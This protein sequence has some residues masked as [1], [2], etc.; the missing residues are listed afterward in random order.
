MRV[1]TAPVFVL[2]L[3]FSFAASAAPPK[4]AVG[5]AVSEYAK[6]FDAGYYSEAA[7]LARRRVD[8]LRRASPV[9]S[10]AVASALL[11]LGR[12]M[13]EYAD[14]AEAEEPLR[15]AVLIE[16][17]L[18]SAPHD[19]LGGALEEQA[20]CAE[21]RGDF[22]RADTLATEALAVR[23]A[24]ARVDSAS[25]ARNFEVIAAIRYSQG[26][27]AAADSLVRRAIGI[28][29]R[30]VGEENLELAES[31]IL[32]GRICTRRDKLD[33]SVP[34]LR[35][36]LVIRRSLLGAEHPLVAD[37]QKWLALAHHRRGDMSV[38]E[39][40]LR[41]SLA[42][43]RRFF[44]NDHDV[45]L[46]VLGNLAI[47]LQAMGKNEE[48]AEVIQ[49]CLRIHRVNDSE[50][51]QRVL[52]LYTNLANCYMRL[53]RYEMAEAVVREGLELAGREGLESHQNT[54]VLREGL[55]RV[56]LREGRLDEARV[57]A[58]T[59]LSLHT[60]RFGE[61]HRRVFETR[62][63]LGEIAQEEGSLPSAIA[64]Y[65]AAARSFELDRVKMG[66]GISASTFT[67]D[68]P[69]EQIALVRA[70]MGENRLAW[71][72]IEHARGR[73]LAEMLQFT[74]RAA[75]APSDAARRDSSRAEVIAALDSLT[76]AR[77]AGAA[78]T[79]AEN[80]LLLAQT[81]WE[82]LESEYS[83]RIRG[84]VR[85]IAPLDRVRATLRPDQAIVGFVECAHGTGAHLE[86]WGYAIRRSGDIQ[87]TRIHAPDARPIR[88]RFKAFRERL[89]APGRSALADA[90]DPGL[91]AVAA[92]LGSECF[93][94]LLEGL[95]G[96][97]EL[98]VVPSAT[99]A[100]IPIEGLRDKGG[101]LLG[102]R[103]VMS[104]A[105]SATI[106]WWLV[107]QRDP[108]VDR[109]TALFV[110]D[111]PFRNEHAISMQSV[112][113]AS[114]VARLSGAPDRT[115]LRDALYAE[116]QALARL[117]RLAWSRSEVETASRCFAR[118]EVFIGPRA[119][120]SALR[121]LG[122]EGRL[123]S[124]DVVHIATHA[125]ID[126]DDPLRS[127]LVLSQVASDASPGGNKPL[128]G[129][130][131]AAEIAHS[132]ELDASLVTL[133]SCETAA[134][135][136]QEGEGTIGFV[137]PF[138]AAGAHCMLLSLWKVDDEATAILMQ[139]FYENWR[140]AYADARDGRRAGEMTK[141]E[142]LREA[143]SWLR[144]VKDD[145]GRRRFE[146]PYFWSAFVLVGDANS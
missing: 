2:S 94:P 88:E 24:L 22:D 63:L 18:H 92:G 70:A 99:T 33:E 49:E 120:E 17:R 126:V 41:E 106:L 28:Q 20:R 64:H 27:V 13:K 52:P 108:A 68:S 12:A 44:G 115:A 61:A 51:F 54:D 121:T 8:S 55:A 146:H 90:E 30:H 76:A 23:S 93:G 103:F 122:A 89:I 133:S 85:S 45:V 119:S 5:R 42:V 58:E 26:Q 35:R 4:D 140:C 131:T 124:F 34:V 105:P 101:A 11:D 16:R 102:D 100:G 69:Y 3:L 83:S 14:L 72:A 9:D 137:Y 125:L 129:L 31:Y 59:A 139:R 111:P 132:W 135:K 29:K 62:S 144:T 47:P 74:E 38:M 107:E 141:A 71:E 116:P 6:K 1:S 128:D 53:R 118:S 127:A 138:F 97:R 46:S 104:Y 79:E 60:K 67:S 130:L 123:K 82:E 87:W 114:S 36:A 10:S 7:D 15:E 75:L 81:A 21:W 50:N 95:A 145:A 56:L 91:A 112:E 48:A 134:G 19:D 109:A 86:M 37:A 40:L 96:V 66:P 32:L 65:S 73:V 39:E 113:V 98:I 143:K 57:H 78:V 77:R 136:Q 25:V 117:P 80:R 43:Q 110:G 84:G 142:A